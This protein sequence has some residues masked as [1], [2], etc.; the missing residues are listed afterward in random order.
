ML[1]PGASPGFDGPN[2]FNTVLL[3]TGV[4]PLED[5]RNV[6]SEE[7]ELLLR[8][9]F[10]PVKKGEQRRGD[11]VL[12]DASNRR[13]HAAVYLGDGLV[14]H[15]RDWNHAYDY[16][17]V[18]ID[19]IF[20]HEPGDDRPRRP[21]EP[22]PSWDGDMTPVRDRAFFRRKALILPLEIPSDL[23]PTEQVL[24]Y[25]RAAVL[26]YGP[27]WKVGV[28]LGIVTENL[29]SAIWSRTLETSPALASLAKSLVFQVKSSIAAEHFTSPYAKEDLIAPGIYFSDNEFLRELICLVGEMEGV[30]PDLDSVIALLEAD[31]RSRRLNLLEAVC[32]AAACQEHATEP[33]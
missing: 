21:E 31:R 11:L 29:M 13:D 30:D 16:R 32:Q 3:A 4:L 18:G 17:V 1:K 19:K 6:D 15:K 20:A 33:K 10:D 27:R 12:Y 5:V 22:V 24:A 28:T 26:K 14:F 2:C 8:R 25:V 9:A 23:R 7:F